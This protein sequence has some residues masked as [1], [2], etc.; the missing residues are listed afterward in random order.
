MFYLSLFWHI[1]ISML[2][3]VVCFFFTP[4]ISCQFRKQ[5]I[6]T[7]AAVVKWDYGCIGCAGQCVFLSFSAIKMQHCIKHT[8]RKGLLWFRWTAK[9]NYTV[10][11]FVTWENNFLITFIFG[12]TLFRHSIHQFC[13][14]EIE[15]IDTEYKISSSKVS[16]YTIYSMQT[17][18][19][20]EYF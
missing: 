8:C 5:Y 7:D 13:K 9:L 14:P 3:I 1:V 20:F 4:R 10:D 11:L 19:T 6:D 12:L 15:L 16:I 17:V 18:Y 2:F